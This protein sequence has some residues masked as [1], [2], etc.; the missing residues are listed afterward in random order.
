MSCKHMA[1]GFTRALWPNTVIYRWLYPAVLGGPWST[2]V[3]I[4][5]AGVLEESMN[6]KKGSLDADRLC[7]QRW[8]MWQGSKLCPHCSELM[9]FND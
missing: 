9:A 4:W 8:A 5:G 1:G 2:L 6:Y 3:E 7:R